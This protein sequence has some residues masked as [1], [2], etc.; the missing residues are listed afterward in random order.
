MDLPGDLRVEPGAA[1]GPV[2]AGDAGDGGVAQPHLRHG[3][4]HAGGLVLVVGGGA[5]GG[6]VAEVAAAGVHLPADEEG[7]LAVVP[8]LVD[9]GAVGLGAHGVQ[10]LLPDQAPDLL[11]GLGDD[12]PGPQPLGLA[13]D[14]RLGVAGLDAQQPAPLRGISNVSLFK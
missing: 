5:A 1:V 3:G 8:A 12:G 11:V 14:G 7:S 13:L 2:I 10:A 6:D 9:V 4:G